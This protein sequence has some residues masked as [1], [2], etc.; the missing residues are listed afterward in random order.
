MDFVDDKIT[1]DD[2]NGGELRNSTDTEEEA[3]EYMVTIP[4]TGEKVYIFNFC[5]QV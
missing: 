1:D 5:L 3:L 4:E 2:G